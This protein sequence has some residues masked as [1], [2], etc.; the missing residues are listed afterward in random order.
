[1]AMLPATSQLSGKAISSNPSRISPSH[2]FCPSAASRSSSKACPMIRNLHRRPRR[3]HVFRPERRRVVS[4]LRGSAP[5]RERRKE[6]M[7]PT[8]LATCGGG[9]LTASCSGDPTSVSLCHCLQCQRRTGST[10][11]IAA[12]FARENVTV[13]G[14]SE[15]YARG[16]DSGYPVTFYFCP[17]C[18]STV[19]WKPARKLELLAVAVGAFAIRRSRR[20]LKP[21]TP[22]TG[23]DG[24]QT[25]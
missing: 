13:A 21:F 8:R 22:N 17:R 12:F 2:L 7:M 24:F 15:A 5:R 16:S 14:D 6:D 11:G 10:Y 9:Q 3:F 25:C 20:L 4:I 19:Y 23:M 18:G 1:C